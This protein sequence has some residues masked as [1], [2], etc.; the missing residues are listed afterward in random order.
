MKILHVINNLQGGGAEKMLSELLP[1][2]KICNHDVYLLLLNN[3]KPKF[4]QTL[5][6]KNIKIKILD[7]SKN[8]FTKLLSIRKLIKS[9]NF[10][11]IH[12]HLFPS[13]YYI[14][15]ATFGLNT[16][17]IYTEHNTLNRRRKYKI[18]KYIERIIYNRYDKIICISEQTKLNLQNHLDNSNIKKKIICISN[19]IILPEIEG[20]LPQ[21]DLSN[22]KDVKLIMIGRFE[23]QKDQTT[24]IK[25]AKYLP[26]NVKIYFAG[27]GSLESKCKKL[28]A[29]EKLTERIHFLGFQNDII[30]VLKQMDIAV[31]S[32][33]WEGFGLSAVE[34]MALGI[35]TIGSDVPG[36]S[37]VLN[38]GGIL[39]EKGNEIKLAEKINKLIYDHEFYLEISKKGFNKAKQYDINKMNSEY[40]KIYKE[41][42]K[43]K[44]WRKE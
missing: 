1:K 38:N 13:L 16:S 10:D 24:L 25:S 35:P 11:I 14:A 21:K 41:T 17:L 36:L 12:V 18:F 32:S 26:K 9:N 22:Q 19:G 5:I 8:F 15:L 30:S 28:T 7:E 4:L 39:F 37:E 33:N 44:K 43:I 40:I 31:L 2:Q 3:K 34:S 23:K 20:N 6:D 29:E 27:T 42:I